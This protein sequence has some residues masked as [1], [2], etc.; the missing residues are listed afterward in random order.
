MPVVR[1]SPVYVLNV[2]RTS[3][4]ERYTH[5]DM[6]T[7]KDLED[8]FGLTARQVHIRIDTLNPLLNGHVHRGKSN[9]ILLD[10]NGFTLFRRLLELER[11]KHVTSHGAVELM[12]SELMTQTKEAVVN[13]YSDEVKAGHTAVKAGET[14]VVEGYREA[15]G[16][17]KNQNEFLQRQV[18]KLLAQLNEKDT[19]IRALTAGPKPETTH[20]SR[21]QALRIALLGR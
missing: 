18:E 17:L 8:H 15:F 9:S 20:P 12:K 2:L 14:V 11:D 4:N 6:K 16:V 21:L 10:D 1:L 7:I 19:H 13:V 5:C 3:F